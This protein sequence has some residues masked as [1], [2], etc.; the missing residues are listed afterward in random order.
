MFREDYSNKT[1]YDQSSPFRHFNSTLSLITDLVAV[2]VKKFYLELIT[3][4]RRPGYINFQG[5]KIT[6]CENVRALSFPGFFCKLFL[7]DI[8]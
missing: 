1:N 7:D 5:F 2:C 3:F 4:V 6:G 8:K